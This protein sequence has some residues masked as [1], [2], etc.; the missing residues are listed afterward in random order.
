[1]EP[2]WDEAGVHYL[3]E[4]GKRVA[5]AMV[6]VSGG[7]GIIVHTEIDE[8]L[9]GQG[10]AARMMEEVAQQLRQRSLKARP[11]CPYARKWFADH[12]EQSDLLYWSC[13]NNPL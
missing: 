3:N 9:Q 11:D 7:V 4:A 10:V 8:A 5:E 2:I 12:P 1:M 13:D 6:E